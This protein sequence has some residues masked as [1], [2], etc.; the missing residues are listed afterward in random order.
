VDAVD[1]FGW[2]ALQA[3]AENGR[4]GSVRVLLAAGADPQRRD[5]N[6][7]LTPL[8]WSQRRARDHGSTP[9]HEEVQ[10]L[11]EAGAVR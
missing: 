7:N 5:P 1:G 6:E 4:R 10:R 11:L 2:R 9:G 3:A 8:E